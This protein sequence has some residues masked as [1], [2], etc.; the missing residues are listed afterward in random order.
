MLISS[1][2]ET[3]QKRFK[4]FRDFTGM[5]RLF[6]ETTGFLLNSGIIMR[7]GGYCGKS[8]LIFSY[9]NLLNYA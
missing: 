5:L 9:L 7:F 4:G 2:N 3:R 6:Q 8:T 1:A